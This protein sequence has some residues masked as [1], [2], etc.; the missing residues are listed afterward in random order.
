MRLRD[1]EDGYDYICTHVDDFKIVSKNHGMWVDCIAGMFLVKEH[2]PRAYYHGNDYTYHDTE[3][4]W[5]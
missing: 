1:G 2:G 3:N 4:M 5:T